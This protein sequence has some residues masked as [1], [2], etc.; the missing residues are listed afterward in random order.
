MALENSLPTLQSW[1]EAALDALE[2]GQTI[3]VYEVLLDMQKHLRFAE[4]ADSLKEGGTPI[5]RKRRT[6]EQIAADEAAKAGAV[7]K[8]GK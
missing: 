3:K 1:T 8:G 4:F 6:A 7:V 2:G 5:K